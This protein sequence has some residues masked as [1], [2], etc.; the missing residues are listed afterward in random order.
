MML[1]IRL[2]WRIFYDNQHLYRILNPFNH[3]QILYFV[4]YLFFSLLQQI[5]IEHLVCDKHRWGARDGAAKGA[6]GPVLKQRTDSHSHHKNLCGKALMPTSQSRKLDLRELMWLAK[7]D[8]F[9]KH[10]NQDLKASLHIF[11]FLT[12]Q[13]TWQ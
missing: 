1:C 11:I 12:Q 6:Q 4:L 13:T 9:N 8:T 5:F 7:N 3:A 10:T 2:G